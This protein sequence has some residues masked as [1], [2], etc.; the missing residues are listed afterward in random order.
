MAVSSEYPTTYESTMLLNYIETSSQLHLQGKR[1]KGAN[2]PG[3]I[4]DTLHEI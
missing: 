4:Q 3:C 2:S 1:P